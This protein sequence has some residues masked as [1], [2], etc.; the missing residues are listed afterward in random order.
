MVTNE[1]NIALGGP[2]GDFYWIGSND[3]FWSICGTDLKV[4]KSM[5]AFVPDEGGC[6][7]VELS[8]LDA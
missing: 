7:I 1:P 6:T 8:A 5:T 2:P 4:Y 3:D